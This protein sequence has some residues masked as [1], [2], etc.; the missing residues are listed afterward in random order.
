MLL[1][2]VALAHPVDSKQ[3]ACSACRQASQISVRLSYVIAVLATQPLLVGPWHMAMLQVAY[4]TG[5]PAVAVQAGNHAFS[6]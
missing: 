4:Q 5:T 2:P 3:S 1:Q 6:S